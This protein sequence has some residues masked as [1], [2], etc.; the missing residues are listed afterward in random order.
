MLLLCKSKEFFDILSRLFNQCKSESPIAYA[1]LY[2]Q[3]HTHIHTQ[4]S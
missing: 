2:T 1:E 3:T 4:N